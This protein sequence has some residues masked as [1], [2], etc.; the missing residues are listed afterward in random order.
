LLVDV[1][2]RAFVVIGPEGKVTGVMSPPR[3]NDVSSMGNPAFGAPRLDAKGRLIYRGAM[4]MA[5]KAPEPG[6]PFAPPELPDTVPI[7][8]ADFDTRTAD[9]LAWIRVP[10]IKVSTTPL[11]GGGVMMRALLNPLAF[12]DDWTALPDGSIAILRGADYHI[13]WIN[14]NG[15]R[16][17]SPK[18]RFDWKRLSDS[19][20]VAIIDSTKK[21]LER[22]LASGGTAGVAAAMGVDHGGSAAAAGHSMAFVPVGGSD[23][24]PAPRSAGAAPVAGAPEVVAPSDLP[25]Y[26]PPV[27][28]SGTMTADG[29]GNVWVL[30]STSTQSGGGLLYDVINRGGEI[31][32]RVR[33]PARRALVGFGA[34]GALYMTVRDASGTHI[35]RA[36]IK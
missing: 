35:E 34:G 36:R 3:A 29:E 26:V 1:A 21:A 30:P 11:E 6:K 17:S 12:I 8:R 19:D 28:R 15:T 4:A 13:D 7:L 5:F 16:A 27:M 10:K 23:G 24:G 31:F 22:S 33:L 9:T 32:Q 2:A 25:D 14:A 18:M 20:K